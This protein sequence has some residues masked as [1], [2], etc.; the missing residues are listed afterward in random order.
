MK[1]PTIVV[2][3]DDLVFAQPST[4]RRCHAIQRI[5]GPVSIVV[6]FEINEL[7]LEIAFVPEKHLVE[8]L[9]PNRADEPFDKR[10]RERNIWDRLGLCD[11]QYSK[12]GALSVEEV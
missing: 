7:A 10:M 2:Q 5:V 9:A 8:T 6:F 11:V 12:V 3:I 1:F 4:H